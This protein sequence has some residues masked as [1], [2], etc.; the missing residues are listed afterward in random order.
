ME[1]YLALALILVAFSV[2]C[3]SGH[4]AGYDKGVKDTHNKWEAIM[5]AMNKDK[6]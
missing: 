3:F 4:A 6:K 5:I 2:G 1:I